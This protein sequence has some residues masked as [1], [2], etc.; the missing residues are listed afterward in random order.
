MKVSLSKNFARHFLNFPKSD[1]EKIRAFIE[2]VELYGLQGL[3]GRNKSSDDVPKD[4]LNWL[5]KVKYAQENCLW[6]YHIGIPTYVQANNG[7]WVSEYVLHYQWLVEH[8]MI[9]IVD[10]SAHP[11]LVLPCPSDFV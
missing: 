10:L 8:D 9:R 2:H 4:D 11:P 5:E 3:Q 6:H 1:Q 7:D